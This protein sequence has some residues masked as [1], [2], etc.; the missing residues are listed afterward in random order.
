MEGRQIISRHTGVQHCC[1]VSGTTFP[2]TRDGG[3][4]KP[5]MN[6]HEVPRSPGGR[7]S[8]PVEVGRRPPGGGGG[9]ALEGG[10]RE[11]QWGGGG[12]W[13]GRLGGG[14]PSGAIWGGEGG[15]GSPY[16]PLPSI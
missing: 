2:D 6:F 14:G 8:P 15:T 3:C 13:E 16:L 5:S 12:G 10:F 9:G 1:M 11:G 4:K 7:L